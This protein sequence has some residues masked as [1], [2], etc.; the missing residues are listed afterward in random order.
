MEI[1][2][3]ILKVMFMLGTLI[4]IHEF[5]HFIVAKACG[6]K[7]NKFSIGFGP[8]ILKKQGKETEYSL[9][10]FPLGGFVQLEDEENE[11]EKQTNQ[12][13][14]PRAFQQKPAWQ[15]LLVLLAGVAVNIIFAIFVYVAVNMSMNAYLIPK[16]AKVWQED[17]PLQPGEEIIRINDKKVFSPM[18]VSY[19]IAET[20]EDEFDFEIKNSNGEIENRRMV[21]PKTNMGYIGVSF[22]DT[23]VYTILEGSAGERAGLQVGDKILSINGEFN[24]TIAEY[25]DIIQNNPNQN[26]E[27]LVNRNGKE[28]KLE[29]M[30]EEIQKRNFDVNFTVVKDLKFEENLHYAWNETKFF[31]RGTLEGYGKLLTGKM[32]NVEMQGIVGISQQISNT[33]KAVDFFAL[34]SAISL[35]LGIM[36]L[37][38]IPGLDGGKILFTLVEVVRR[39]PMK[40]ETEGKLTLAGFAL[41]L[42][43]MVIVTFNDVV[44]LF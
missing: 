16:V 3:S 14:D 10:L 37:L 7:V 20:E 22:A 36:N 40:R 21:I 17:L 13:V 5:G 24:R 30:P 34:M 8:K 43:L 41:L 33:E 19:M 31:L 2:I 15:R 18:D 6:M 25:L 4:V 28:I 23:V 27:I 11:E 26:L 39:K 1:L 29:V 42:F 32:E 38:P 9:R 35:S 12:V 44:N